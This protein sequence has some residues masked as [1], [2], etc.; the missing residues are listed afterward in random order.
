MRRFLFLAMF[1][2]AVSAT[3]SCQKDD[4][5][6]RI[7]YRNKTGEGYVFRVYYSD[8]IPFLS[9]RDRIEKNLIDSMKPASGVKV[10]IK[11]FTQGFMDTGILYH[12]DYVYTNDN[13]KYS[14]KLLRSINGKSIAGHHITGEKCSPSHI[15]LYDAIETKKG[16]LMDTL[17]IAHNTYYGW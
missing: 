1:F 9:V 3:I 12:S 16:Y 17:F 15:S 14:F 13:G 10:E 4:K 6:Q 2:T 7:S 11:A 5:G 8:T